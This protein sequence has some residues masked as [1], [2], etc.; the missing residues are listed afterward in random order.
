MQEHGTA[1]ARRY[2]GLP[3]M[4]RPLRRPSG[5]S[6]PIAR[7]RLTFHQG[8]IN[9]QSLRLPT[10]PPIWCLRRR[11]EPQCCT[12]KAAPDRTSE[13]PPRGGLSDSGT[14]VYTEGNGSLN[15]ILLDSCSLFHG[16]LY[17]EAYRRFGATI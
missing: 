15:S 2:S 1:A 17:G 5:R 16:G 12:L 3:P 13:R 14:S 11:F 10:C 8:S 9:S 4:V 6:Q 7:P